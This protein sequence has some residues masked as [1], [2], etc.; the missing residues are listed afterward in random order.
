MDGWY[1]FELWGACGDWGWNGGGYTYGEFYVKAKETLYVVVGQGGHDGMLNGIRG[2]YGG[3]NGG[4]TGD[5]YGGGDGSGGGATD[6]RVSSAGNGSTNWRIG[7]NTRII[8]AGGGGSSSVAG[9]GGGGWIGMAYGGAGGSQT[10]G[11]S[12]G[13][14]QTTNRIGTY[15]GG[16]GWYGG[17]GSN[18]GGGGGSSYVAGI[19]GGAVYTSY[20]ART[21]GTLA[22]ANTVRYGSNLPAEVKPNIPYGGGQGFARITMVERK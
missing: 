3:W 15:G 14:G 10:S 17:Y 5:G 2:N 18:R 13:E 16:G 4:G 19:S 20:V 1:K 6:I 11:Y 12:F 22:N 7:L 8:V 21:G 9:G